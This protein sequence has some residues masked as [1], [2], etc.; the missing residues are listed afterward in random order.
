MFEVR[1]LQF[2]SF[3]FFIATHAGWTFITFELR[4]HRHGKCTPCRFRRT[5]SRHGQAVTSCREYFSPHPFT[6]LI[7]TLCGSTGPSCTPLNDG[8][9]VDSL[10]LK[11][12]TVKYLL[13]KFKNLIS[14]QFTHFNGSNARRQWPGGTL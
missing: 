6:K 5:S 8:H 12:L 3:S 4:C 1:W 13:K 2:W 14:C 10:T 7:C 11:G 9:F